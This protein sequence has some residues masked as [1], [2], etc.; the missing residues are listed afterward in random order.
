MVRPSPDVDP[1]ITPWRGAGTAFRNRHWT[2]NLALSK[3][4]PIPFKPN[5]PVPFI[6]QQQKNPL[7]RL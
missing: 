5:A 6:L 1:I 7:I 2:S 3:H 4:V